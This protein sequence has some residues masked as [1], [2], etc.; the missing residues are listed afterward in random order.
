[1]KIKAFGPG[2]H[3]LAEENPARVVE[4]VTETIGEYASPAGLGRG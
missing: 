1:M 3:C 2:H 4:P